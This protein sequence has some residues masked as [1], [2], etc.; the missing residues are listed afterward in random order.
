M[1]PD[2]SRQKSL[3]FLILAT[4]R[5]N[6]LGT[7]NIQIASELARNLRIKELDKDWEITSFFQ[8]REIKTS[9]SKAEFKFYPTKNESSYEIEPS[10]QNTIS[11]KSVVKNLFDSAGI[12]NP[13]LT[14]STGKIETQMRGSKA[15]FSNLQ[16]PILFIFTSFHWLD[17]ISG[18]VFNLLRVFFGGF[19]FF[20]LLSLKKSREYLAKYL[21][22]F[23]LFIF[24]TYFAQIGINP[25]FALIFVL[26]LLVIDVMNLVYKKNSHK[27]LILFLSTSVSL[28]FMLQGLNELERNQVAMSLVLLSTYFLNLS[29]FLGIKG[30]IRQSSLI[31]GL[32]L[33]LIAMLLTF[34]LSPSYICAFIFVA[35]VALFTI[36]NS[37]SDAAVKIFLGLG[38]VVSN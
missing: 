14:S 9:I 21:L 37:R 30:K 4:L 13:D 24:I 7:N 8:N 28:T 36:L 15:N 38:W 16:I 18:D 31:L 5:K 11:A 3:Y 29:K 12:D 35:T 25:L 27:S 19:I 2:E 6:V 32:F 26:Q 23:L 17:L 34:S 1:P 22:T 10:T 20:S 33:F